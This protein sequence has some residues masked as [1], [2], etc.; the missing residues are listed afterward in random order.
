MLGGPDSSLLAPVGHALAGIPGVGQARVLDSRAEA[1]R[2]AGGLRR[3]RWVG[4]GEERLVEHHLSF[5]KTPSGGQAAQGLLS[6]AGREGWTCRRPGRSRS[7]VGGSWWRPVSPVGEGPWPRR[8]LF[9]PGLDG[10]VSREP[11]VC[12]EILVG[13]GRREVGRKALPELTI[14]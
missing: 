1:R 12:Y 14:V 7:A 9:R 8:K 4:G 11:R 5:A 6:R 2:V 3:A 13:L 10:P